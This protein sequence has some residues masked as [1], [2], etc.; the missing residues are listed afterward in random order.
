MR[1]A[2]IAGFMFVGT[3][4]AVIVVAMSLYVVQHRFPLW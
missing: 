2:M 3:T 1:D 4:A